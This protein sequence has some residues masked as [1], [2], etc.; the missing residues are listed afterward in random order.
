LPLIE[1]FTPD[2]LV[3]VLGVDTFREDP[4]ASLGL[5]EDS[6]TKIGERLKSLGYPKFFCFA[7]GYSSKV[8][9]LWL[10]FIKG[11]IA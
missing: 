9:Q 1:E 5:T 7:G 2:L 6:Y 8:P 11:L 3:I 4:L 10:N